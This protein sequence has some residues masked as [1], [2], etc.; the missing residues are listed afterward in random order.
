MA[1]CIFCKIISGEIK[2]EF[3]YRDDE[4]VAF[5]DIKPACPVHFLVVPVKHIPEPGEI[6][7]EEQKI[8]GKMFQV[9]GKVAKELGVG[10]SGYRM[11]VNVGPDAGQEIFHLHI[12]ILGG[13][14]FGW[15]PG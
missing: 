1:D 3:L 12:H 5:K 9:A 8:F 6:K 4:V 11:V 7:D 10:E 15:P 14:K 2:T 13:K